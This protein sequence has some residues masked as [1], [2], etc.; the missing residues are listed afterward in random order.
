MTGG[1]LSAAFDPLVSTYATSINAD[2]T[3]VT[4]ATDAANAAITINGEVASSLE[5]DLTDAAITTIT[6][7][8]T[9]G[10]ESITYEVVTTRFGAQEAYVKAS[11]TEAHDGFG[12]AVALSGDGNTLAVGA[13]QE[14]AGVGLGEE[15][16]SVDSS[17]AVYVYVREAS[18]WRQQQSLKAS[19]A[20][21]FDWF[22][23]S[24]SLS[25]DGR[26]LVVGAHGERSAA[27]GV[28]GNRLDNS[29]QGAGAAY[30][31]RSDGSSWSELVYLK[32]SNPDEGDG[33][34]TA[35]AI[36]GDASVIAVGAPGEGSANG[37][38]SNNELAGAGAIYV[39]TSAGESWQ[40]RSYLKPAFPGAGDR[41]GE[42][43]ALSASGA[44]LVVGVRSEDGGLINVEADDTAVDA[45]AAYVF[46]RSGSTWT[47]Q[48]Y[49]KAADPKSYG[50]FADSVDV[51][52][53]G[54]WLVVG[55]A[56]DAS[57][58][59][60]INGDPYDDSSPGSG[61]VYVFAREGSG[62]NEQAYLKASDAAA[63]DALG[64]SV[65]IS[66]DGER[67]V[68]GACNE[69]ELVGED[70]A[71]SDSGAA[72]VFASSGGNWAEQ[73]RLKA[74]N[75]GSAD[76][77]GYEIAIDADG[78]VLAV[79]APFEDSSGTGVNGPAQADNSAV[80]AGAA[81]VFRF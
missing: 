55:A 69:G 25:A 59:T 75:P 14:S 15:D 39:F 13:Y 7:T 80:E 37:S 51:S 30:V 76:N 62:W 2:A 50:N 60:T 34:G 19:N 63:Y 4:A 17:G 3:T 1:E 36:S 44:T 64:W 10:G 45:G 81:Y 43:L 22:G 8:V 38:Q 49:L 66:D 26:T 54:D 57:G 9:A 56:N 40:L 77:F 46:Q 33:F 79:T 53:D 61:A 74:S 11:N 71:L 42:T 24:V 70:P 67:V 41:F 32:A 5:V 21:A 73:V 68:A 12:F 72:Y 23:K 20:D 65:A 35:V 18:G 78:S 48:A 52:A 6:V 58:A 28:N 31:F 47:Q 27:T 16:N 29:R